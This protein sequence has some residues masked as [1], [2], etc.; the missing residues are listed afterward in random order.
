MSL[1][2]RFRTASNFVLYYGYGKTKELSNFDIAIIEPTA[3]TKEEINK[4]K[5]SNTLVIAYISIIEVIKDSPNYNLLNEEDF[6]HVNEKPLIN[7]R[8]NTYMVSL[9][10]E[11]WRN[12]LH[13]N[14]G[15]FI[16]IYGYDGYN[17]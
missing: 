11:R 5:E 16:N 3:H 14:I 4:I 12:I 10:S 17:W 15:K 7:E 8:F 6:I 9:S 2:E 1:R 13:H